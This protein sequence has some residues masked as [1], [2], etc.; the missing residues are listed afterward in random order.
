MTAG[1]ILFPVWFAL[2]NVNQ[3]LA[4]FIAGIPFLAGLY[5]FYLGAKGHDIH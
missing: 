4:F 2:Q 3:P 1:I 5:L